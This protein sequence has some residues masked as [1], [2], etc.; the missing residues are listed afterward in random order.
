MANVAA[1]TRTRG[2]AAEAAR[3]V[4]VHPSGLL[5]AYSHHANQGRA[6]LPPR[7]P[8]WTNR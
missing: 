7:P 2:S 5:E 4:T 1:A 8:N 3:S 6:S